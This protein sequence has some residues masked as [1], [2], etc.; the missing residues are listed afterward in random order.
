VSTAA[1]SLALLGTPLATAQAKTGNS[2]LFLIRRDL[3][4]D[5][6]PTSHQNTQVSWIRDIMPLLQQAKHERRKHEHE[7]KLAAIKKQNETNRVGEDVDGSL[8]RFGSC[9]VLL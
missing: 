5:A 6:H 8:S 2:T 7:M 4:E 9:L 3:S 1:K